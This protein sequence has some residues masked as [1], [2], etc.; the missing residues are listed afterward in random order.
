MYYSNYKFILNRS[1][2]CLH[3]PLTA[4][5]QMHVPGGTSGQHRSKLLQSPSWYGS[6]GWASSHAPEVANSIT[7]QVVALILS[8]MF[9]SLHL[10]LSLK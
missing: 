3:S 1:I 5:K 10:P 2:E 7:L 6:V 9:L 4:G 8:W